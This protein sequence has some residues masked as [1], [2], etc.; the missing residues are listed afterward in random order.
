MLHLIL[1]LFLLL[2]GCLFQLV[3]LR[4]FSNSSYPLVRREG[5][6]IAILILGA[7]QTWVGIRT[8]IPTEPLRTTIYDAIMCV[9]II[10]LFYTVLACNKRR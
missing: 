4:F 5:T 8:L 10:A 3:P 1:G 2:A 7:T 9:V 6:R